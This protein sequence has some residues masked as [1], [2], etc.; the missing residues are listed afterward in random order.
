[1]NEHD[2]NFHILEL[3][4]DQIRVI[5]DVLENAIA[6]GYKIQYGDSDVKEAHYLVEE[7][8]KTTEGYRLQ[9]DPTYE[10]LETRALKELAEY[11]KLPLSEKL[12]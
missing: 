6:G 8:I 11:F 3:S 9:D 7:A 10:T 4:D 12:S 5:R 1:M 2:L